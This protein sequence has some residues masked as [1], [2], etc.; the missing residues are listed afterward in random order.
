MQRDANSETLATPG[1]RLLSMMLM[2]HGHQ[3]PTV[4]NNPRSPTTHGRQ[5][6]TVANNPRSHMDG[7][8]YYG[9]GTQAGTQVCT[10]VYGLL[11]YTAPDHIPCPLPEDLTLSW[12]GWCF[13]VV[14]VFIPYMVFHTYTSGRPPIALIKALI[15]P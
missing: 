7:H 9:N 2:T 5:Q 3:Q 14:M 12:R 6:P 11:T 10:F 15:R 13:L 4:A 1:G 8:R